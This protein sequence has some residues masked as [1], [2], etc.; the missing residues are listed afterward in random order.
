MK[1][2]R[3]FFFSTNGSLTLKTAN[4]TII[5]PD[6]S[7]S[8]RQKINVKFMSSNWKSYDELF[9]ILCAAKRKKS[10]YNFKWRQ[11]ASLIFISTLFAHCR[12]V[13]IFAILD[14]D[15]NIRVPLLVGQLKNNENSFPFPFLSL[16]P[17]F[18][19]FIIV[20]GVCFARFCRSKAIDSLHVW[21]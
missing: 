1:V 17:I 6:L 8:E 9:T 13:V 15:A 10:T 7:E 3:N 20:G 4:L 2:S 18:I 14:V 11:T 12:L 5:N 16:P 19:I 21:Y